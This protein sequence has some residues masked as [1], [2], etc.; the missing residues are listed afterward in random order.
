MAHPHDFA[1]DAIA[2]TNRRRKAEILVRAAVWL[3]ATD[4]VDLEDEDTRHAALTHA[5]H[6]H[7]VTSASEATWQ[8]ARQVRAEMPVHRLAAGDDGAWVRCGCTPHPVTR[9]LYAVLR[10]HDGLLCPHDD[11]R[12]PPAEAAPAPAASPAWGEVGLDDGSEPDWAAMRAWTWDA[13]GAV[14][15][16]R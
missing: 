9:V 11:P 15:R 6:H 10:E 12:V 4:R 5:R 8:V 3:G 1:G 16:V 13:D 14:R 7:S 2:V